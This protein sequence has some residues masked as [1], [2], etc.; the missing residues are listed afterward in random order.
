MASGRVAR[1]WE[2]VARPRSVPSAKNWLADEKN[3]RQRA[4]FRDRRPLTRVCSLLGR[5]L[6]IASTPLGRCSHFAA[7]MPLKKRPY[8]TLHGVITDS[9]N[10]LVN[11]AL[12]VLTLI[13]R[14]AIRNA[15]HLC[16]GFSS[17]VALWLIT[18][19]RL[20][21]SFFLDRCRA[22]EQPKRRLSDMK[23]SAER[24]SAE[25][26]TGVCLVA[27]VDR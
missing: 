11:Y 24:S 25:P 20:R 15:A 27:L 23:R 5:P 2:C 4:Y 12:R 17:F 14:S 8:L 16:V 26:T 22:A 1:C 13:A 3:V 18:Q 21:P 10:M 6:F 19:R 7:A 9:P